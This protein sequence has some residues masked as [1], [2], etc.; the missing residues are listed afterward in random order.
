MFLHCSTFRAHPP[1]LLL[2]ILGGPMHGPSPTSNLGGGVPQSL[3]GLRPCLC[4]KQVLGRDG[5]RDRLKQMD[6]HLL[7]LFTFP[8]KEIPDKV[9]RYSIV[10]KVSGLGTVHKVRHA[11][12]H[13]FCHP[14]PVTLCHL[15]RDPLKYVTGHTSRTSPNS[16]S[17][18]Y[19]H[20]FIHSFI[21]ETY[22]A[23]L[24]ETT[25]QRRSQP[26]HGQ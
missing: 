14:P 19:I 24:Q 16:L 17:T 13:Q 10:T 9:G 22:I 8:L 12:L 1:T 7:Q 2:K 6:L 20:S 15:S 4:C 11:I 18:L 5:R 21:L 25:T 23:P 26:S 3:L